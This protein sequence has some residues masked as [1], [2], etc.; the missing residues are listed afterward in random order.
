MA[1]EA[2]HAR[3]LTEQAK[4]SLSRAL[5]ERTPQDVLALVT[6]LHNE[7]R[8]NVVFETEQEEQRI[9]C[10]MGLTGGAA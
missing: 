7:D 2:L 1:I 6:Q 10:S 5:R 9:I 4:Q 3:P 8:L